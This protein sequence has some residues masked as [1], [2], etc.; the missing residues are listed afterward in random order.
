MNKF[1]NTYK[2]LKLIVITSFFCL[3]IQPLFSQRKLRSDFKNEIYASMYFTDIQ[4][5]LYGIGYERTLFKRKDFFSIQNE[6]SVS[7]FPNI[8]NGKQRL[9]SLVKWN[10]QRSNIISFGAGITYRLNANSPNKFSFLLNNAYKYNFKKHKFTFTGNI[11]LF[12][13]PLKPIPSGVF[14]SGPICVTDCPKWSNFFRLSASVGKY[15]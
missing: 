15:F 7:I 2:Y 9:L 10:R 12:I 11:F 4:S 14:I 5:N 1:M 3:I 13:T 6:F 8:V